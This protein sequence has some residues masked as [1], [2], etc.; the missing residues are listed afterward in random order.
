MPQLNTSLSIK[1]TIRLIAAVTAVFLLGGAQA[2]A[3]TPDSIDNNNRIQYG[4]YASRCYQQNGTFIFDNP[5]T[6]EVENVTVKKFTRL[7]CDILKSVDSGKNYQAAGACWQLVTSSDAGRQSSAVVTG[8][9]GEIDFSVALEAKNAPAASEDKINTDTQSNFNS[10]LGAVDQKVEDS[11]FFK[12]YLI[13]IINT[14]TGGV[15]A[16]A[17][18]MMVVSGIQYSAGRDNPQAVSAAKGHIVNII[19]G[20]LAFL[21]VYAFLQFIIPGGLF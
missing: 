18:V 1:R 20:L 5:D 7:N 21:F 12:D 15:V 3:Q 6:P 13:P 11:K 2:S 10:D 19:I 8:N 9:C 4:S 17:A 16:I 14:L